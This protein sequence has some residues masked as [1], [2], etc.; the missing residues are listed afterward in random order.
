MSA[1]DDLL[2][3]GG[4]STTTTTDSSN[5]SMDPFD[6]MGSAGTTG[7]TMGSGGGLLD[8]GFDTGVS[9]IEYWG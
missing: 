9:C 4:P 7:D 2:D 1:F 6:P 3:L 5:Q 8:L